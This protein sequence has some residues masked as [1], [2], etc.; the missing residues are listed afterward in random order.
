MQINEFK[1][2]NT[3]IYYLQTKKF[4]TNLFGFSFILPLSNKY[5]PELTILSQVFT[6]LTKSFKS[7]RE[8]ALKLNELYDSQIFYNFEKK[9]QVLQIT[10]YLHVISDKFINTNN[11]LIHDAFNLFEEVVFDKK[12]IT[13]EIL[14]KEKKIYIESFESK[15]ANVYYS[16][17]IVLYDTMFDKENYHNHLDSNIEEINKVTLNSLNEAYDL[18]MS[19]AKFGFVI[20]DLNQDVICDLFKN[21]PNTELS[22]PPFI[23]KETKDITKTNIQMVP[24]NL[25]QSMLLMG[26]RTDIRVDSKKYFAMCLLNKY[27]GGGFDSLFIKELR[28]NHNLVYTIGSEYDWYK[29]IM[30]INC[31]IN[32]EDY[33]TVVDLIK[34]CIDDIKNKIIDKEL[35][36]AIKK[37]MI[38][39]QMEAEDNLISLIEIVNQKYFYQ[40]KIISNQKKIDKINNVTEE[41][42]IEVAKSLLLD[43]IVLVGKE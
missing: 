32:Y 35:L 11:T 39:E 43:T 18:L 1:I 23:D 9:G 13:K 40:N 22:L 12:N 34:Q 42:I 19:S 17:G 26:Y 30:I 7:E 25:P 27:L 21:T 37:Q 20:G 14:E 28:E 24:V 2:N 6:K 5:L 3:S 10:F 33:E 15:I 4:K 38:S 29:G 16:S 36:S 8:F 41:D 31:G